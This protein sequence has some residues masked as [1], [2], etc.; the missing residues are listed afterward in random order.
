MFLGP[1]G[2][3]PF[4]DYVTGS[5]HVLPTGGWARKRGG[6][7]AADFVKCI[8][9]QTISRSGFHRLAG[10]AE[11]LAESEGLMAHRSAVRVRQ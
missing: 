10:A 9:V 5:N 2:A 3:Q 7:S 11:T 8:S 1:W 6:L 4:G